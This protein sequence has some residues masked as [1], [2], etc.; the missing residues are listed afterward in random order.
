MF[1]DSF[2]DKNLIHEIILTAL[3]VKLLVGRHKGHENLKFMH[4]Y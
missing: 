4:V 3:E 2:G 1:M